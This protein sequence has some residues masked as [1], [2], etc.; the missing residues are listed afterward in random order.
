MTLLAELTVTV[1]MVPLAITS[2]RITPFAQM[3]V[4]VQTV[5]GAEPSVVVE[6]SPLAPVAVAPA[7]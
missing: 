2:P 1:L 6:T 3:G 7:P 4:G 5:Q